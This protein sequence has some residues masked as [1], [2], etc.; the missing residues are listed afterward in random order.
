MAYSP[1]RGALIVD[2]QYENED[3]QFLEEIHLSKSS[4]STGGDTGSSS[5]DQ[6]S[7]GFFIRDRSQP[8]KTYSRLRT[9]KTEPMDYDEQ[10]Y[11]E[12]GSLM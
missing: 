11:S 5:G 9:I 6:G 7:G 2:S 4:Q 12:N 1:E 10:T 8:L 3:Q